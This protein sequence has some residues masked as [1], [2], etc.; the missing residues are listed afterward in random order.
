MPHCV[1]TPGHVHVHVCV[2]N[3]PLP[4]VL[5]VSILGGSKEE[6]EAVVFD[7]QSQYFWATVQLHVHVHVYIP[8][9]KHDRDGFT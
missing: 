8:C 6:T 7:W 1:D 9:Y 3:V 2:V 5:L 4:V